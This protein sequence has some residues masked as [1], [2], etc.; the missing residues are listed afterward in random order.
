[1]KPQL[2]GGHGQ[3]M[4]H[5]AVGRSNSLQETF[6]SVPAIILLMFLWIKNTYELSVRRVN[7]V[8]KSYVQLIQAIFYTSTFIIQE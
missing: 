3:E 5:K 4:G 1:L 7:T 2:G 6:F 8:V